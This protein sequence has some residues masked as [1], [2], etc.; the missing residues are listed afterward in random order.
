MLKPVWMVRSARM[1]C[2]IAYIVSIME[3]ND[4]VIGPFRLAEVG[5]KYGLSAG[6]LN[7]I[8][9]KYRPYLKEGAA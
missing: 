5:Q 9:K 4:G 6:V 8:V 2:A 3:W 7:N 1:K